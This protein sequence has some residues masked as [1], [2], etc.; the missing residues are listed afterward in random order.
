MVWKGPAPLAGTLHTRHCPVKGK[1]TSHMGAQTNGREG[2]NNQLHLHFGLTWPKRNMIA[3]TQT[4]TEEA[5]HAS[6]FR[7]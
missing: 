5:W 7:R 1:Q 3:D 6:L 4:K 2:G